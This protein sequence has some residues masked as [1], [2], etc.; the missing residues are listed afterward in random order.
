MAYLNIEV[1]THLPDGKDGRRKTARSKGKVERSF[2]SSKESLETLYHLHPP[3]D[4][5]EANEWLT[6]YLK[7]YNRERHRTENH[8][9]LEDWKK[10]LPKEGFKAMCDW[11][12]FSLLVCEP[13]T[14]IVGNDACVNVNGVKYQLSSEFAGQTVTL[15]MGLFDNELRISYENEYYGPFYPS[16]GPIPFGNYR[17]FKKT[18]KEKR[19]N[20]IEDLAK[21]ISIPRAVLTK[22]NVSEQKLINDA[23]LTD[24]NQPFVTFTLANPFERIKFKNGLEAKLA[25]A[26][27]LGYPLGCLLPEQIAK[28]N[29]IVSEDL[30]KKFVMAQVKELFKIKLISREKD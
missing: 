11:E 22:G 2:R 25:I 17:H 20:H 9:R 15:L 27:W 23:N 14:R 13:E 7:H 16:N 12:H 19:A 28:I 30:D 8:S 29:E 1:L 21:I 26:K 24:Q 6:H 5:V 10:N 4:L 18:P 3:Q